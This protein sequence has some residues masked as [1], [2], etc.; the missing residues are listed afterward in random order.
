VPLGGVKLGVHLYGHDGALIERDHARVA[1]PGDGAPVPPGASV[2]LR[3]EVPS[4]PSPGRYRLGFDLVS[5]GVC[6]FEINGSPTVEVAVT[7]D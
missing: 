2:D 4:P 1:L 5:E 3:L 6:W 7:V